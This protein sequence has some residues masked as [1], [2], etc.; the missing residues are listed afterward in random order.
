[1]SI[2]KTIA[3][4]SA[5]GGVGK[6]SFASLL[7]KKL[8]GD[9]S[10]GI[11]DADIYGPNQH[12]IFDVASAKPE[13]IEEDHK[14]RFIPL[15][16]EGIRLNSMGFILGNEK[17][18]IWRGPM[19]SGAIKQ[20]SELTKWGDLDYLFIDMPPGTGDA[21]LTVA[22]EIKPDGVILVTSNSK[23]A[24]SDTLKSVQ[25]FKKLNLPIMGFVLNMVD[26]SEGRFILSADE[27][28]KMLG[29]KFLGSIPLN[30][31][32][33]NFNFDSIDDSLFGII[34][35]VTNA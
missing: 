12:I 32:I 3:I 34:D 4:A 14:K 19:L 7:A 11:L 35:N 21:Y 25:V 28:E 30:D 6:S 16:I 22:S 27:V 31:E 18:A 8:S 10:I 5:K 26:D 20:L 1:M 33:K 29:T 13:I 15:N 24:A 2:K 23:L 17:A 9:F